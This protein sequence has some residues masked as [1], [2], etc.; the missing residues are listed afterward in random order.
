VI[1]STGALLE[2][3]ALATHTHAAES[4]KR[5]REERAPT[6]PQH[7][8]RHCARLLLQS[9]RPRER[10]LLKRRALAK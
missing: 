2:R 1:E 7:P 8:R 10:V 4:D 9:K 3:R 6:T 5:T